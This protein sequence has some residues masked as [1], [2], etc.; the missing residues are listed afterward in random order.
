MGGQKIGI[1]VILLC[2]A[3]LLGSVNP[4]NA[5][6]QYCLDYAYMTCPSSGSQKLDPACNCC[7]AQGCTLYLADGTSTY[8]D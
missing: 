8:C 3:I 5:C 1:M 6:P 7:L 4:T 2:G